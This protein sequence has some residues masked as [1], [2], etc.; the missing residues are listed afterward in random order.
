MKNLN[1]ILRKLKSLLLMFCMA[2]LLFGCN[3][4]SQ[5]EDNNP[6]IED[7]KDSVS[8]PD[9]SDSKVDENDA[10]EDDTDKDDADEDD[11]N[12]DD[13]DEDDF[14]KRNE[15]IQKN[16]M[17]EDSYFRE[18]NLVA[19]S[20]GTYQWR[21]Y[22]VI[23]EK[24]KDGISYFPSYT[25]LCDMEIKYSK[26]IEYLENGQK[27]IT[28]T[29]A[30]PQIVMQDDTMTT[31][32]Y[33]VGFVDKETGTS[34]LPTYYD[35]RYDYNLYHGDEKNRIYITKRQVSDMNIDENLLVELEVVCPGD[36]NGAAFCLT[37]AENDE[38]YQDLCYVSS[39]FELEHGESELLFFD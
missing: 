27:K 28:A 19:K 7:K 2:F 10:D 23:C 33:I 3:A 34:Y 20:A 13:T 14:L 16:E 38:T 18:N 15:I 37:G 25:E 32:N 35:C 39:I 30:F 21:G 12:E 31:T 6:K 24:D 36:Y 11:T 9:D 17:P 1:S 8:N 22:L 4:N 5:T 26:Q 29:F